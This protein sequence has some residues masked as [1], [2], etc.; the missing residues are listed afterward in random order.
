MA[1]ET[2][3]QFQKGPLEGIIDLKKELRKKMPHAVYTLFCVLSSVVPKW[4]SSNVFTTNRITCGKG[5][6]PSGNCGRLVR[7]VIKQSH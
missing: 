7:K 3:S 4:I 5:R 2:R 1:A 6:K